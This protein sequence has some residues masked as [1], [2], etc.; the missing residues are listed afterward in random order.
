MSAPQ[1]RQNADGGSLTPRQRGHATLGAAAGALDAPPPVAGDFRSPLRSNPHSA[2]KLLF[3][4]L[5]VPHRAQIFDAGSCEK[6]LK[7]GAGGRDLIGDGAGELTIVLPLSLALGPRGGPGATTGAWAGAGDCST[8]AKRFP[9]SRQKTTCASFCRPQ[10]LQTITPERGAVR[11][12]YVK[13]LCQKKSAYLIDRQGTL[14]QRLSGSR[15]S[16]V[17]SRATRCAIP[18]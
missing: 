16:R 10:R 1:N 5:D 6:K 12:D 18:N 4:W 3:A 17:I 14:H 7:S 11:P 13:V 15:S 2:Q 8:G 9:Q